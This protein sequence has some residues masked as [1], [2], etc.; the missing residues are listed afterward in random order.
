MENKQ[1][2]KVFDEGNYRPVMPDKFQ[3]TIRR[4]DRLEVTKPGIQG[5][6]VLYESDK[7]VDIAELAESL[8][9][10]RPD[11]EFMCACAGWPHIYLYKDGEQLLSV[12]HHHGVS[13][14]C[15]LWTSHAPLAEPDKLLDWF[16][17]RGV[18]GPRKE[19]EEAEEQ[20]RQQEKDKERWHR[21]MPKSIAEI[22]SVAV[23]H[24]APSINLDIIRSAIENE[25]P[26]E[27]ERILK[28]LE[29]YGSG[30]G[31]WSGYYAYEDAAEGLLLDFPTSQLVDVMQSHR[32]NE[33][34]LEGSARL[35][36][37]SHLQDKR[38]D[39]L[40]LVP[41]SLKDR[42]WEY[43]RHT[44]DEDKRSRAKWAFER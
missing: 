34:Q 20:R 38:P 28:I 1:D 8:Q 43:V 26:D 9:V 41:Q 21:A 25:I 39:D 24:Q 10:Y 5:P 42:L 15:P 6:V 3:E 16:D 11:S 32:L 29:W 12:A 4:A 13:V 27:E 19:L 14:Y 7:A 17:K 44:D 22:W 36:A 2:S 18:D 33:A 23:D 31:R 35:V 40:E 37:G 30:C